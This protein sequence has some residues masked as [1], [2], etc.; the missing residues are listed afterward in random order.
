MTGH[1]AHQTAADA[2]AGLGAHAVPL[3]AVDEVEVVSPH[4]VVA[5]KRVVADDPYLPG[6]Y[7]GNPIYPGVFVVESAC[8]ATAELV[9]RTRGGQVALAGVTSA[10][11]AAPLLPGDTLRVHAQLAEDLTATVSCTQ[12]GGDMVAQ[13]RLRFA[14]VDHA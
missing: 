4:E 12:Q 3:T 2:H 1:A 5:T 13:L 14:E 11:F 7:P 10:R 8:Q 9:R 6:H